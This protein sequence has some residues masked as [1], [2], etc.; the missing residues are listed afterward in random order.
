M[1]EDLKKK[2]DRMFYPKVIAV[3][4]DKKVSDYRWLKAHSPFRDDG[5]GGKIYH[6][7]VDQNEWAGAEE[8]GFKNVSSVQEQYGISMPGQAV[9]VVPAGTPDD[10]VKTLESAISAATKDKDFSDLVTNKLKFPVKFV[11]S[12][13]LQKD[14]ESTTA[15]LKK[16]IE[17]TM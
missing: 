11:G 1:K 13:E 6:V 8:L 14:I 2:M 17:A 16:V 9:I 12:D 3:V 15:A 10:V 7:N 5:R 4:G